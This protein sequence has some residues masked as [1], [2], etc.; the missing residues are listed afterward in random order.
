MILF[1]SDYLNIEDEAKDA[2]APTIGIY[3]LEK[4]QQRVVDG[5]FW[6][7]ESA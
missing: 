2:P 4:K 5:A 7:G 6:Y 3:A 1:A